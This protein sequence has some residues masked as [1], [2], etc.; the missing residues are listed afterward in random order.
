MIVSKTKTGFDFEMWTFW[1]VV[2]ATPLLWTDCLKG[3]NYLQLLENWRA[4]GK[5]RKFSHNV[6]RL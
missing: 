5:I 2:Y 4:E 1:H 3:L 6:V